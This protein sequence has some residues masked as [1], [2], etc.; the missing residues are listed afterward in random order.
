MRKP[1]SIYYA[2]GIISAMFLW[3]TSF[4]FVIWGLKE[5]PPL[6]LAFL[7][8]FIL[9]PVLVLY[10][11]LDTGLEKA[12]HSLKTDWR[13]LL[14]LSLTTVTLP[15]IFQNLGMERNQSSS[16]SSILQSSGPLFTVILA[17]MILKERMEWYQWIGLGIGLFGSILLATDGLAVFSGGTF[18]G[19][20]LVMLSAISY[21]FATI[22][23]KQLLH[24]NE[25]SSVVSWSNII[26]ALFL[27]PPALMEGCPIPMSTSAW[28]NILGL[29]L[30]SSFLAYVIWYK[31]MKYMTVSKL[32]ITVYLIPVITVG[33]SYWWLG[34]ILTLNQICFATL[35]IAGVVIAQYS[36]RGSEGSEHT[37]K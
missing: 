3:A 32:I 19:N 8:Y 36:V 21:A 33:L 12:I 23:G 9:I 28:M 17:M 11:H 25:P 20:T 27:Y 16:I 14:L 18:E 30:F 1:S 35:I 7:R 6:T 2:A 34:E 13:A 4:P 5:V 22:I 26:G 29:A 37:V 15:N 31:L 10:M 24:R